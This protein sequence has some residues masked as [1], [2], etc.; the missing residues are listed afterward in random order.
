LVKGFIV[1][2]G[3]NS[4]TAQGIAIFILEALALLSAAVIRPWI[5]KP[6][7]A[8]N[9]AICAVNFV[10]G[11]LLMIFTNIFGGPGL[12]IGV[13]GVIFFAVNAIFSLVLLIIILV[14]V[15]YSLFRTNPDARYPMIA[16]NRASFIKSQ[17]KLTAELDDLAF[18]AR[19]GDDLAAE[20][21]RSSSILD[22]ASDDDLPSQ[23]NQHGRFGISH[24]N[25]SFRQVPASPLTPSLPF[26]DALAEKGSLLEGNRGFVPSRVGS[27]DSNA[28]PAVA[29]P[30][31]HS[32]SP[33][34]P[35]GAK[36]A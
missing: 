24:S 12:L 4:G 31:E 9:I 14:A 17:T 36:N 18:T 8:M 6:T 10:N 7:N 35:M 1:A 19:G 16:D 13:S 21:F 32:P 25:E 22:L 28:F 3:Q 11:V 30:R 15:G 5:D 29:T 33:L 23:I 27:V 20:K 26:S 34:S 2:L